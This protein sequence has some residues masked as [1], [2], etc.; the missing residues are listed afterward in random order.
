MK[1]I[2]Y[3][4]KDTHGNVDEAVA[5]DSCD[6]VFISGLQDNDLAHQTFESEGYHIWAWAKVYGFSV[7]T[8]GV[9]LDLD[10]LEAGNWSV[11]GNDSSK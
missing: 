3:R 2:V 7:T 6:T 11:S 1:V 8:Y 10:R 4:V 5:E 9:E